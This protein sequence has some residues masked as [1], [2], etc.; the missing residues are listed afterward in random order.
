MRFLGLKAIDLSLLLGVK[1]NCQ[2]P[3][4]SIQ[5]GYYLLQPDNFCS[6]WQD[7]HLK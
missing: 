3:D 4:P 7:Q 5:R 2:T 6:C 1:P